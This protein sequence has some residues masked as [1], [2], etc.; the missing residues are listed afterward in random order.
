[1]WMT[2]AAARHELHLG[3]HVGIPA[4]LQAMTGKGKRHDVRGV[5][6]MRTEVL[7]DEALRFK[8]HRQCLRSKRWDW[9]ELKMAGCVSIANSHEHTC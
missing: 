1:M 6:G 7:G 8:H 9:T 3:G 4:R 5:S 2:L